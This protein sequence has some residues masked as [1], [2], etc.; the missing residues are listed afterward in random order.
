MAGGS[1]EHAS[2]SQVGR[3]FGFASHLSFSFAVTVFGITELKQVNCV[4]STALKK[5]LFF[6]P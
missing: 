2:C 4:T 1:K 6:W 5:A 3:Y